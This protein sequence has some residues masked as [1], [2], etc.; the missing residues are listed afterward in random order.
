MSEHLRTSVLLALQTSLLGMVTPRMR[1]VTCS[2]DD[3]LITVKFVFENKH[4]EA[5]KDLCEEVTSEVIS[6]F[7]H[8][9][10]ETQVVDVA[11]GS[12]L[13]NEMLKAWVYMRQGEQ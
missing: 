8:Q 10:I 2:R 13:R 9:L 4:S 7:P 12:P 1:G 11:R 3:K 6:H 5:D